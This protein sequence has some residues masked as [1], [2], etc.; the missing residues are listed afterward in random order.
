MYP[1][2]HLGNGRSQTYTAFYLIVV[3]LATDGVPSTEKTLKMYLMNECG[4]FP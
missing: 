4:L 3:S 2:P 1:F